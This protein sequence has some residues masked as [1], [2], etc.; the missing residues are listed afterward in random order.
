MIEM[1]QDEL[2]SFSNEVSF[3]KELYNIYK[4]IQKNDKLDS[5]KLRIVNMAIEKFELN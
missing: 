3:S 2:T 4:T 1:F 5:E